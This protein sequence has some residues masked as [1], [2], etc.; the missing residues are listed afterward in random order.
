MANG[1]V[2]L[3][4]WDTANWRKVLV[5]VAGHLQVDVVAAPAFVSHCYGYDGAAWQRLQVMTPADAFVTPTMA[6]QVSSFLMGYDGVDWNMVRVDAAGH[7]QT[8]V[9]SSALPAGAATAAHQVTTHGYIDGLEGLLGAGLPATLDAGHLRV[10]EQN[11]PATYP[12]SAAQIALLQAVDVGNWPADYPLPAAQVAT[13]Q[14]VTE[15]GTP[16]VHLYGYD[17]ANWQTLLVESAAQ[18]NLRTRL[19]AGANAITD[20]TSVYSNTNVAAYVGLYTPALL[21]NLRGATAADTLR[22]PMMCADGHSGVGILSVALFG[23]NGSN[24][25]RL[26]VDASYN[27]KVA[28]QFGG[29]VYSKTM[30]MTDDNATRFEAAAKKLRDIVIIVKTHPMLLGET[31]VEVYPVG[32]DET[33]GFTRVDISTL[34]FKNA[35]AGNNGVITILGVEE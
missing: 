34:Y 30:T 12:L 16:N 8:D 2:L 35:G 15:Q 21:A 31:G 29:N 3:W 7:L 9:L 25:D 33:V 22:G 24:W 17:G 6:L 13:L 26:R 1:G 20:H 28:T 10:R 4:G 11:W 32:A 19:Y 5:D 23:Y 18:K 14:Q 27:L